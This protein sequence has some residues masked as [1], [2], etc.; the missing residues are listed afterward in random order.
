MS[1]IRAEVFLDMV[2]DLAD[3][4][5]GLEPVDQRSH[6]YQTARH[7]IGSGGDDELVT[8]ALLHD[9]GRHTTVAEAFPNLPHEDSARQWL[10]RYFPPRVGWLVGAH[11]PAKRYIVATEPGYF[12]T[13]SE[14]SVAS[15]RHQDGPMSPDEITEFERHPWHHAAVDLRRWDDLAK[16]P[17]APLPDRDLVLGSVRAALGSR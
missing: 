3:L 14:G 11:V 13:L 8:A 17:G 2:D 10:D 16:V 12:D 6:A 4:P 9:I 15:F 1:D 5:Y 7:A